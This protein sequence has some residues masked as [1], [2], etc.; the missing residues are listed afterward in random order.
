MCSREELNLYHMVRSHVLYPLSYGSFLYYTIVMVGIILYF[1]AIFAELIFAIGFSLVTIS[2]IYSS[3]KGSPYVPTRKKELDKILKNA[4]LKP[5]QIFVELG[6][7]DGRVS[8]RAAT[9]YKVKALGVDVNPI[10]IWYAKFLTKIKFVANTEFALKNIFDTDLSKADIVY[11]FLMPK[12]IQ[13]ILPKLAKEL[14][15]KAVVISHGFKI[16]G[17]EDKL[18]KKIDGKPF[19]T[20]YYRK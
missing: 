8:R 7:G 18:F 1:I 12:L 16:V 2:F 3:I 20:Y 9:L 15:N 6:C 5:R 19:S 4:E 17:W 14:K 10:L 13:S 11:L